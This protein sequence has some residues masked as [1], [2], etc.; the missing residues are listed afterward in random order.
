MM[1]GLDPRPVLG[2]LARPPARSTAYMPP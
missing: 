2:V 1:T